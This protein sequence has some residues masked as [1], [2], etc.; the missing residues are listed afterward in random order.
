MFGSKLYFFFFFYIV[1]YM[2]RHT[3]RKYYIV[4][5]QTRKE[6]KAMKKNFVADVVAK[7]AKNTAVK[8]ANSTCTLYFYQPKETKQI[9]KLRKF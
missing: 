4:K 5:L 7:A 3:T 1:F 6:E 8:S 9:K 2:L